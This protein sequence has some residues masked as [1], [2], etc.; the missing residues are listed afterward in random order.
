MIDAWAETMASKPTLRPISA[1]VLTIGEPVGS[2]RTSLAIG[3]SIPLSSSCG[4]F[5]RSRM[6]HQTLTHPRRSL[7]APSESNYYEQP[8]GD[9][10]R[11]ACPSPQPSPDARCRRSL[12][13]KWA[14]WRRS[15]TLTKNYLNNY[16][17]RPKL[18]RREDSLQKA[19]RKRRG[20]L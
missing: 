6:S 15:R 4:S 1:T 9:R 12:A 7:R 17:L 19:S 8:A 10:S 5:Y 20:G 11:A 14:A 16:M 3:V 13:R 18:R 2:A